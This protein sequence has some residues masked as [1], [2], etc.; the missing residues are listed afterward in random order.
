M[1]TTPGVGTLEVRSRHI[2][3]ATHGPA[4]QFTVYCPFRKRT[5]D[6]ETCEEC[7]AYGGASETPEGELDEIGCRR[8]AP[9]LDLPDVAAAVALEALE[10][11]PAARV[12]SRHVICVEPEVT[13]HDVAAILLRHHLSS[14]PVVDDE[15]RLLGIVTKAD[16]LGKSESSPAAF[17]MAPSVVALGERASV[18]EAA[19][20]MADAGVHRVPVTSEDGRIVG[21]VSSLD[22]M[23]FL[24]R[25]LPQGEGVAGIPE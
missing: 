24:S 9:T 8:L 16:L 6:L 15:F 11:T 20:A 1:H 7:S 18:I 14:V 5:V 10:R 3:G 19:R 22:V 2:D 17:A 21:I 23:R 12:M 13:V 25:D 4:T